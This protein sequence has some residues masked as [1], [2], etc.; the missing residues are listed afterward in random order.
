MQ[1][2]YKPSPSPDEIERLMAEYGAQ[3]ARTVRTAR[4][5][6]RGLGMTIDSHG[7]VIVHETTAAIESLPAPVPTVKSAQILGHALKS[8]NS[9]L[10]V[11]ASR[12][13]G[14]R[15]LK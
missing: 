11:K 10:I 14:R 15:R 3:K 7:Q 1:I 8:K 9:L 6:L 13:A 2:N 5:Y 4:A 12:I